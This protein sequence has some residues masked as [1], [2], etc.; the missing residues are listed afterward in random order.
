MR[1]KGVTNFRN[2]RIVQEFI[3]LPTPA[4]AKFLVHR[5]EEMGPDGGFVVRKKSV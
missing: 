4:F 2:H 5:K 3:A 1:R